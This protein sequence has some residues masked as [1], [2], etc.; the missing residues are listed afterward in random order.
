[1][2]TRLTQRGTNKWQEYERRKNA[3]P[4]LPP[5]EYDAAIRRICREVRV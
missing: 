4:P 1:M 3:L 5:R 2:D